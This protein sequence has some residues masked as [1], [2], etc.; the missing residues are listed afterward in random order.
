[1][2]QHR[3]YLVF[4]NARKPLEKIGDTGIVREVLKEGFDRNPC[5]TKDPGTTYFLWGAF[6]GGAG[7]PSSMGLV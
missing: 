6:Y 1:M 3:V 5:T 4:C 7:R 2:F